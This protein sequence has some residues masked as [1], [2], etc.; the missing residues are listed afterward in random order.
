MYHRPSPLVEAKRTLKYDTF[1]EINS[2]L[3]AKGGSILP[4]DDGNADDLHF[5]VTERQSDRTKP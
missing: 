1:P 4:D 5:F 2:A 3:T